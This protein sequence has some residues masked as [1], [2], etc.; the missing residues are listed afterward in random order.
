MTRKNI[1]VKYHTDL[2][3]NAGRCYA[4]VEP[5]PFGWTEEEHGKTATAA[6]EIYAQKNAE[7]TVATKLK[8][9]K[10][11]P[12]SITLDSDTVALINHLESIGL[13]PL[14]VGGTVRDSLVAN[15]A[16]KDVDIEVYS[17]KDM[18]YLA[19]VLRKGGF[20]VDEVGKQFGVL[21]TVLPNGMD[22]DIS[23]PRKDN[24]V[25]KG[26]R[27]FEMEID[28]DLTLEEAANRRDFTFNAL[29]YDHNKGVIIDPYNGLSDWEKKE[30]RPVSE[31]FKEDPLRVLRGVQF[32][33]RFGLK[34]SDEYN[35]VSKEIK[36]QFKELS[37]E[38]VQ[39]EFSKLFVKG[40]SI[41]AGL[42]VLQTTEW[43]EHFGFD[44]E[45]YKKNDLDE[46]E[47]ETARISQLS[48]DE[49]HDKS[50]MSAALLA[51]RL[52]AEKRMPFLRYSLIGDKPQNAAKRLADSG[53]YTGELN[54]KE[55]KA[56]SRDLGRNSRMTVSEWAAINEPTLGRSRVDKVRSLALKNNSYYSAQKDLVTGQMIMDA[57]GAKKGGPWIGKLQKEAAK[58]QD[59]E[60]FTNTEAAKRWVDEQVKGLEI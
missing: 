31:A 33:S 53:D 50:T 21:K 35:E 43:G 54:D 49:N 52:P 3:G 47:K 14:I 1:P 42:E 10:A 39:E 17:A 26:H 12:H 32:A 9:T 51:K 20:K 48:S 28:G 6:R 38:R 18:D 5:C 57:T 4:D 27:G 37:T 29:Y 60:V 2:K 19:K 7:H 41:R 25:G 59:E 23:L 24:L 30:I 15:E 8:K 55:I 46:I 45:W 40:K 22:I 44:K 34:A 56:W 36:D 11:V 58:A 16:P 13:R